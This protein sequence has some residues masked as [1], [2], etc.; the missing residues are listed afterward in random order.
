LNIEH[1]ILNFEPGGIQK[2]QN[3]KFRVQYSSFS[4]FSETKK[5]VPGNRLF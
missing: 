5:P 2:L 4:R 3:S 1:G